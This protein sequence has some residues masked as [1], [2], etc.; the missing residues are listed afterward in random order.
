MEPK[1][2]LGSNWLKYFYNKNH[3]I[4]DYKD[5][6]QKVMNSKYENMVGDMSSNDVSKK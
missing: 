1:E 5:L 6:M 2:W 3:F 4:H